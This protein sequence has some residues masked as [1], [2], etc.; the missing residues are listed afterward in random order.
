ME[1][2]TLIVFEGIDNS[3]KTS[4]SK[5]V[6]KLLQVDFSNLVH[7]YCKKESIADLNEYVQGK[8][9]WMWSKEPDF[10]TEEADRLNDTS[11]PMD[12]VEREILFLESRLRQ[13]TKYQ[14]NSTILDRYVW[15][16]MAYAQV[17]SPSTFGFVSK[18]YQSEHI[19]K[20]PALTIFVDTPVELCQQREP[21]LTLERL[22][23][24]RDAFL[25]TEAFV[26]GPVVRISGEGDLESNTQAAMVEIKKALEKGP[27]G[28]LLDRY[29]WNMEVRTTP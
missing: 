11:K 1:A 20:V 13:L 8:N 21:A 22:N 24:I 10:S 2:S 28:G 14:A 16:G 23:K 4:I 7:E 17:F 27:R 12:E 3:G 6:Q 19:F 18:L 25:S 26:K 29:P 9:A 15:T 5:G